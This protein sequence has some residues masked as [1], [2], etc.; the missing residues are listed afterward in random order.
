[1]MT[2]TLRH[3]YFI[4]FKAGITRYKSNLFGS[5]KVF[6]TTSSSLDTL[7]TVRNLGIS[8]HIDAGKTTCTERML[9]F[10]GAIARAGEVHDGDTV[11]D[12]MVQ[13]RERGITIK[14]AAISFGWKNHILNLI[15]TPGHVD[16]T[17]EVE[18]SMRVLDGS[19]L[20]YDAVNGVEAQSETVFSQAMRY[21]VAKIAFAN[22]MDRE[23][24]S[25]DNVAKSMKKR[26]GVEPL[27]LSNALGEAGGFAGAVDLISMEMIAHTDLSGK[28]LWRKG[29]I[30]EEV[31]KSL[32]E[33]KQIDIPCRSDGNGALKLRVKDVIDSALIAREALL[34][35]LANA[36]DKFA[37]VY[38]SSLDTGASSSSSS[39][40]SSIVQGKLEN[41]FVRMCTGIKVEDIIAALRRVVCMSKSSFVPL[42]AGSAYKNKG[43]Q[44]LLDTACSLLPSPIDRQPLYGTKVTSASTG[45]ANS[46]KKNNSSGGKQRQT[47]KK[48]SDDVDSKA[49]LSTPSSSLHLV[50]VT[51]N[52]PLCALA[53]KVQ[54]SPT[55]GPLVFFRVYS[56][57]LTR[58]Q[59]LQVVSTGEKER[60][61]KLLQ[62]MADEQRE[63]ES[64]SCGFIGAATGL[65]GVKT[66]DTL[67]ISGDPNPLLLPSM[68]LPRP[69]FTASLEVGSA[70]EQKALDEALSVLLREDPSLH[71][72]LDPDT[73]QT[74]LSG[75]GELHLDIACD[76][77]NREYNVPVKLGR[78]MIAYRE[79]AAAASEVNITYDKLIGGKRLWA[80]LS[81]TVEPISP[82]SDEAA[83]G[84]VISSSPCVF[85]ETILSSSD[86]DEEGLFCKIVTTLGDSDTGVDDS[87]EQGSDADNT[88]SSIPLKPMPPALAD[89]LRESVAAALGRGPLF[90]Y[91]LVGLRFRLNPEQCEIN[92]I[93]S[94][95]AAIRA[96]ASRAVEEV[97][98]SA[99]ALLLEPVMA[100][101]VSV[102]DTFVGETL[103]DLSSSQRRGT[104]ESVE[105]GGG[106]GG[107]GES[108]TGVAGS[109]IRHG[110]TVIR[111]AVPLKNMLGFSTSL[112]SKTGGDGSFSM[113]LS[114]YDHVGALTQK[115]LIANPTLL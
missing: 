97:V 44:Q 110:N 15:D 106:G 112:R 28:T 88:S 76:R 93:N 18:R 101:E 3:P 24:A 63:V 42:L 41:S 19:V 99:Q 68:T 111:A 64:I 8:A 10:S 20:L 60:P 91:P 102:P 16:F 35:K 57:V 100:V 104:I 84:A 105:G 58:S 37:D 71:V 77:L 107:G 113:E 2:T 75:M 21:D 56:G 48:T 17:M 79:S 62:V 9:L 4:F 30:D 54:K 61:S 98:K 43:I 115:S 49:S 12:F 90:G 36:D 86:N 53:F 5:R 23:G 85:D 39:S 27:V 34:E 22:K 50:P 67:C 59:P 72:N 95:P 66:G 94:T 82:T 81:L 108:S 29:L 51:P 26:L 73:G 52:A 92:L 65:K 114:R 74:L 87:N 13:E 46:G 78:L 6:S 70:L 47:K 69:V 96:C 80:K 14:A 55:R 25:I 89:A 83:A 38:L 45:L 7:Q 11:T 103:N 31:L 1:M 32:K 40:S 33:D 109:S